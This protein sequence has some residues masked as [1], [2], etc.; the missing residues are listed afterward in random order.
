MAHLDG[1]AS[2]ILRVGFI[3]GGQMA[4]ALAKVPPPRNARHAPIGVLISPRSP[5]VPPFPQGWA[6]TKVSS[7]D[8]MVCTVSFGGAG[9]PVGPSPEYIEGRPMDTLHSRIAV[10]IRL[11][12]SARVLLLKL[13]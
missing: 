5:R 12:C 8:K 2:P 6:S 10:L 3:G 11:R 1:G 7:F 9:P 13:A 4:E